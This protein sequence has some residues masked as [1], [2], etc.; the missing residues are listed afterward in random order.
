MDSSGDALS[1]NK[2]KLA[3][4]ERYKKEVLIGIFGSFHGSR[5]KDLILLREF[6]ISEGYNARISEDLDDRYDEGKK[7]DD[8]QK[9]R[10]L[11]VRLID[12]SDA[13]IFIFNERD[14]NEPEN[15]IQSVS[16]ELERLHT[17]CENGHLSAN[18]VAIYLQN[19][20]LDSTGGVFK[21]LIMQK[22]NDWIIGKFKEIHELF[23][24]VR[25][26]CYDCLR[27]KFRF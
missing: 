6:L 21:G 20:S 1:K 24:P 14:E 17:L 26:V 16:M 4:L 8:P 10:E 19:Q 2:E 3:L 13:H 27:D 15:L 25:Q 5:K 12:E 22:K 7:I 23:K 9:N 11:S 18:Y